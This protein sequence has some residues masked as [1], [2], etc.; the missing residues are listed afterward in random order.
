MVGIAHRARR[1]ERGLTLVEVVVALA[2]LAIA[3]SI[4]AGSLA[5][6]LRAS[7]FA[8]ERSIALAAAES[9]LET[10]LGLGSASVTD[11]LAFDGTTFD[12]G[13]LKP[14]TGLLRPGSVSID[15]FEA[16]LVIIEVRVRYQS[17][18]RRDQIE[19]VRL[20]TAILIGATGP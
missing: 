13:D 7:T 18:T 2:L 12:A 3:A 17:S 11:L 9:Q 16:P 8:R 6:S 20:R 10:V 4:L 19:E 15:I 1:A 5:A 14:I